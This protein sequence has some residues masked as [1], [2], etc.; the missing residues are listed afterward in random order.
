M[1]EAT[2]KNMS[3]DIQAYLEQEKL[4]NAKPKHLMPMLIEKGYFQND[5]RKGKPLRDILRDLDKRNKLELIPQ[6]RAERKKKNIYWYFNALENDFP[7]PI[8]KYLEENQIPFNRYNSW[9]HC[10]EAFGNI[11][12]SKLLSLHLGFYLASWG[13]YRGSSQLLQKDYLVHE[14]AVKIID[15][16]GDLRCS[17]KREVEAK[18]ITRIITLIFELRNHYSIILGVQPS[19]TLISKVILGTLGCLP[20]FDRYFCDGVKKE[21][22]VFRSITKKSLENLFSYM[23]EKKEELS[24]IQSQHA[25]IYYPN[26]KLIDTYFWQIGY[27]I[28]PKKSSK[29]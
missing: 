16:F 13:M 10:Y 5:N 8:L 12:D 15:E 1:N 7:S 6:A 18:D 19:D 14:G 2:L 26:M 28:A 21:N 3:N 22:L 17:P 20:A 29:K 11:R 25:E 9:N 23:E 24:R 4:S 27:E